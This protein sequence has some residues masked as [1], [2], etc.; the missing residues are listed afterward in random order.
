MQESVPPMT[1]AAFLIKA[2]PMKQPV[3]SARKYAFPAMTTIINIIRAIRAGNWLTVNVT[4]D[5]AT[6]PFIRI[7]IVRRMRLATP[8]FPETMLNIPSRPVI[9]DMSLKTGFVLK[10]ANIQ[11]PAHRVIALQLSAV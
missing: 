11:R 4:C 2:Y 7:P 8:V 1:A 6:M 10:A 5:F 9:Q 3:L